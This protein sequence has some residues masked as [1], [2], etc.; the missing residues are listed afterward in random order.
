MKINGIALYALL[1]VNCSIHSVGFAGEGSNDTKVDSS[2]SSDGYVVEKRAG[3]KV[4]YKPRQKY[5]FEG[6]NVD[7]SYNK[8]FGTSI[9]NLEGF[10]SQAVSHFESQVRSFPK[11]LIGSFI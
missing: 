9:T 3:R 2:A 10:R 5:S 6:A 1:L 4:K 7:G 11:L 8:P